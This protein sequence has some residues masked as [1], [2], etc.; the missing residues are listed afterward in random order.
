MARNGSTGTRQWQQWNEAE[1]RG[2][3]EELA[4]SGDS[5]ASFARRSGLMDARGSTDCRRW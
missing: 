3:L 1:A 5:M 4:G 2:M